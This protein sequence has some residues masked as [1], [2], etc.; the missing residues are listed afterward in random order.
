MTG[1]RGMCRF[2][3]VLVMLSSL[4]ALAQM[5]GPGAFWSAAVERALDARFGSIVTRVLFMLLLAGFV[6]QVVFAL[7]LPAKV[8]AKG[9]GLVFVSNEQTN[10]VAVIDPKKDY[11]IIDWIAT[12]QRP[13]DMH[14][15]GEHRLLYV[16]CG[17]DDVIDVIDVAARKVVDH[18]S[19][20][21]SPEM[22][23]L[24]RDGKALYV[25]NEG[26]S[27]VQEI[28][29]AD[30]L[31]MREIATGASPEG[32]ATST[33]GKTLYVTSEV[34]DMVHVID[35]GPG[36]VTDNIIVGTR[37]RRFLLLPNGKELWVSNELSGQVSVIDRKTN[38]V[39]ATIDFVPPGFRQ[40]DVTP[41]G[42]TM[43]RDGKIAIVAL[44][45]ANHIAFVDTA[46][47]MVDDYVLVGSR[48]WGVALSPDEKTLYVTNGLSDDLS[49]VDMASRKAVRAVPVGRVP[50]SVLVDD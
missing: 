25:S 14:F 29:I 21:R 39:S 38:Q 34:T 17:G 8:S 13:R 50:H 15:D 7:L 22:F 46:T 48:A 33:D 1:I 45:R 40:V 10:N 20:G 11:K 5:T 24:T 2:V 18:I 12:S 32:L 28:G 44:G 6:S 4:P 35:T 19:T 27:A 37:P 26:A 3:A 30:K 42:M 49:I 41:V 47:K 16:A 31:I 43:T 9:T 36:V 23:I